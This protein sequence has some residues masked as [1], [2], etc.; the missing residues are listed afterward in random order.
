MG[1]IFEFTSVS[2]GYDDEIV[3]KDVNFTVWDNDFVGV[4]G[5]NGGGRPPC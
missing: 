5:P 4:I 2:A 3:L 1:K